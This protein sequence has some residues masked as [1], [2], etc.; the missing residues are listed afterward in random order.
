MDSIF[1]GDDAA[2]DHVA[3]A[4]QFHETDA[5]LGYGYRRAADLL[6]ESWPQE[7]DDNLLPPIVLLYRHSLELHLKSAIATAERAK[8]AAGQPHDPQPAL[9]A[10][11]KRKASHNLIKLANRLN[12][13]LTELK[14]AEIDTRVRAV[15]A[16]LHAVDPS[17]E[18]FRYSWSTSQQGDIHKVVPTGRP[19]GTE[20]CVDIIRLGGTLTDAIRHVSSIDDYLDEVVIPALHAESAWEARP[21][22][23]PDWSS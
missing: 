9:A 4:N 13:S 16:E 21:S 7:R 8:Q 10:W 6:V 18:N 19:A 11:F 20:G 14:V 3:I 12:R 15:I 23:Q 1:N 5:V 22:D 17:G 2:A